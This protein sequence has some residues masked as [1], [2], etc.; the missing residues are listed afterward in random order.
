MRVGEISQ[1]LEDCGDKTKVQESPKYQLK[2][3]VKEELHKQK[4][5]TEESD[6]RY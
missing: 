5:G 2:Q 1:G 6:K 3:C 4:L